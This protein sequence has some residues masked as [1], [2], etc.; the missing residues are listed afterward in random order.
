MRAPWAASREAAMGMGKPH[1][2]AYSWASSTAGRTGT[3]CAGAT[4]CLGGGG[5][6]APVSLCTRS[7]NSLGSTR[8]TLGG[9]GPGAADGEAR[10]GLAGGFCTA[11]SAA[12]CAGRLASAACISIELK[13]KK[14]LR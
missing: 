8:Y 5:A 4:G 13:K 14:K 12:S 10:H 2:G 7:L 9:A 11:L 6:G 1:H 3:G